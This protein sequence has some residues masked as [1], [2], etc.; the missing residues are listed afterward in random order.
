[1]PL[2]YPITHLPKTVS[3]LFIITKETVEGV[4]L[5]RWS[6]RRDSPNTSIV[7]STSTTTAIIIIINI[8]NMYVHVQWYWHNIMC[9]HV[10]IVCIN[11]RD[12]GYVHVV[13]CTYPISLTFIPNRGAFKGGALEDIL[14]PPWNFDKIV[15][16]INTCTTQ[17]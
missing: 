16:F 8:T 10:H 11:V 5:A 14:P 6:D 17:Y 2:F 1:M 12:I 4:S 15:I 9:I 3:V 7:L 13:T